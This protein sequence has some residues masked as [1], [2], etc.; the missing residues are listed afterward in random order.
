MASLIAAILL[1]AGASCFAEQDDTYD[2][3]E[4][5]NLSPEELI[6]VSVISA[7]RLPTQ[8]HYL[9]APVTIITAE[10]IHY[11][12]ATTIPEI[13]QFA[14]GRGCAEIRP[15]AVRCGRTGVIWGV[16]GPDAG[17]KLMIGVTDVLNK[18]TD[19]VFDT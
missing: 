16:F 14:P 9:S 4:L 18:T 11:N 5:F 2:S 13:L 15:P 10:D 12:G 3:Q 8:P 17:G 19:P 6:N 7:S 1:V